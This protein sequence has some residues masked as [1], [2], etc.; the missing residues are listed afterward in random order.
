LI[1]V[2]SVLPHVPLFSL[3][4]KQ[5]YACPF[6]S[7]LKL[8][9]VQFSIFSSIPGFHHALSTRRGG[10][11]SGEFES[12]NLAFHV[13]DE[14]ESVR[15][16][17]RLWARE[18]GFAS[19]DLVAAQQVHGAI[20]RVVSREN[21][22]RGAFGVDDALPD[23]D[24]LITRERSVP[25]LIL[26]ADCAPILLVDPIMR[27]CAVVHAGWRGALAGIAAKTVAAMQSE[28]GTKPTDVLAAIGPCLS[29]LNLEVGEEVAAQVELKDALSVVR[30][31]EWAKPHLNLRSLIRRDLIQAGLGESN[32]EVSPL[33][34]K[35]RNDLLFS[36]R[37]QN[38]R[39]GRFGIVA[40]WE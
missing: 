3:C 5:S 13:G 40:W 23:C 34:P 1:H 2:F 6:S 39:A 29:T 19:D 14:A 36:H 12:L 38:G 11:S 32:V 31:E 26:V 16:N 35:E 8:G 17:R 25:I 28:W 4:L 27:V 33:C 22:G 9:V 20:V 15:H 21:I 10:V 30:A 37:G 18:V 7:G 24:A